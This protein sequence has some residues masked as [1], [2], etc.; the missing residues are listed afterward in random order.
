MMKWSLEG[1]AVFVTA[2]LEHLVDLSVIGTVEDSS[3]D[4]TL[5]GMD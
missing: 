2:R 5:I 1:V 4:Q 3:V